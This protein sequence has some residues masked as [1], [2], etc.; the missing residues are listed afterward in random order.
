[1]D[2]EKS[3][4][5]WTVRDLVQALVALELEMTFD[6]SE[7]CRRLMQHHKVCVELTARS[8]WADAGPMIDA[9]VARVRAVARAECV[10]Q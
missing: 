7:E 1:M 3:L 6:L 2:I 5:D 9:E 8:V 10:L 4:D